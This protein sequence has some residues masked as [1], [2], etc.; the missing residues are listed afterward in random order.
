M[1]YEIHVRRIFGI[2]RFVCVG[3]IKTIGMWRF[4]NLA[5]LLLN[6]A[7]QTKMVVNKR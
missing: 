4:W 3:T 5:C 1:F 7:I 6:A 2:A